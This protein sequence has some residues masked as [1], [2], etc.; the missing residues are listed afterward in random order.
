MQNKLNHKDF[1]YICHYKSNPITNLAIMRLKILL[2]AVAMTLSATSTHAIDNPGITTPGHSVNSFPLITDGTPATIIISDNDEKGIPTA[3]SNLADDF[4]RVSGKKAIIADNIGNSDK[5]IVAGTEKNPLIARLIKDGRINGKDL[6]GKTEKYIMQT[7]KDPF[8][9]V[10]EALVIAGSDRRGAIYGIYEL[11]EQIGVSPWYDWADVP[12]THHDNL[13]IADGT[14]TAGE[15]AVRYRGIFLNDEAP[16][17]TSWV[18]NTYGTD[19]GDHRFYARVCELIL[20]LRG[21]YL[22]PAMWNWAFYADDPENSRTADEMGVIIGTSH[23]EPMARNHQEW[24]R[25]RK[26]YGNWNYNTNHAV[27][28]RFFTDGI[29]RMKGTEDIVT[30]G[31]R[32]DGDEAMSD[33]ADV[34]LLKKIIS[35]QRKIISRETGKKA[36]KTPQMWALYK[37]VL[38]YYDKGLHAPD[39][40]IYLLCDDN[41][42]NVRRLPDEEERKHPG[43]WGMYYHVDY[44]GAPRNS[45]LINVTP[46]QRMWEQLNLTYDYG[47]D[48]LWILNV[49]DLKPMEYPITLFLDMAWNPKKYYADHIAGHTLEFCR[50]QFGDTQAAEAARII[51]LYCKYAGRVTP[52]MLDWN[53]Y[54]LTSGEWKSVTDDFLRLEAEATRQYMDLA[55]EYRDSYRQMVLFPVQLMAN[56]YDMYYSV[57]MNRKLYE[58]GNPAANE[59]ADKAEKAFARDSRLLNDYNKEI[60]GGK[61]DGMMT[62]KHIGYTSWNDDFPADTMPEVFRF[63][64]SESMTGNYVFQPETDGVVVMEAEHYYKADAQDGYRWQTFADMGRT[65]SGVALTPYT[66]PAENASLT[67]RLALPDSAKEVNVKVVVKSTLAFRNLSGHRYAV[68][69]DGGEEKTVNFN[70]N[71]NEEPQNIYDVF[72]PTVARRVVEKDVPLTPG[73]TTDGM[74]EIT[75]RPLDEGIVFEKIV[76]DYG[77]YSPSYLFMDETPVRR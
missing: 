26:E 25:N 52:E 69:I 1:Y 2:I 50:Q 22:W 77:G 3:A 34:A 24:A 32:G 39:D 10:S 41:W 71:L 63:D 58:E 31:M 53:T 42:G 38:D 45:K 55:P 30:I 70:H 4:G 15:P 49:G 56:L 74:H 18:K 47:V 60:A 66:K 48:K 62:Q 33:S 35:N 67:Y 12:V 13:S 23:H 19:Y 7:V 21:N 43:G 44:V 73:I 51:N 27:I 14:Y 28:D 75:I 8:P 11:S 40:V 64:N 29:R 20:R 65:L 17:L 61:W 57:A 46:I 76:V 9:G 6:G 5:I 59:W 37:E 36:D 54:N 72:Y 16:C 68:S